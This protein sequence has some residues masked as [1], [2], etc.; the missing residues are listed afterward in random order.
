M[1]ENWQGTPVFILAKDRPTC[2]STL[3]DRLKLDGLQNIFILDSGSTYPPMLEYLD[4]VK[5]P[6]IRLEPVE[7]HAPKHL[8][9]DSRVLWETGNEDSHFVYTDCDIVP[10]YDCPN[11]WLEYLF[12]LLDKYPKFKKA[13]LGLRLDDIPDCYR[14]KADVIKHETRYWLTGLEDHVFDSEL[15]TTMALYAPGTPHLLK[16]I[17]TGGKYIARHLPWYHNS[18]NLPEEEAYYIEH[19]HPKA[20]YWTRRDKK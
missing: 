3:L 14:H 13:G 19:L 6:V 18:A 5:F 15:D 7:H 17:R 20:S 9:W 1:I 2:L 12:K 8:L 10:D 4:R 11:N 16:A